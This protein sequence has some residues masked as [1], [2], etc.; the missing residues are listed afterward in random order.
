MSG[1]I[2]WSLEDQLIYMYTV[3]FV[4]KSFFFSALG[5]VNDVYFNFIATNALVMHQF[6]PN[7]HVNM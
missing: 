3:N 7:C 5:K 4:H 1:N 6:S 2:Y